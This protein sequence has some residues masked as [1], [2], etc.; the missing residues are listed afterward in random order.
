M[1]RKL[2]VDADSGGSGSSTIIEH[3][4]ARDGAV[5]RKRRCPQEAALR[6]VLLDLGLK[7]AELTDI[8]NVE[9]VFWYLGNS[10]MT[11]SQVV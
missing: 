9:G 3:H 6:T 7:E 1:Q 11:E 2:V 4:V 5:Q 10:E 8:R